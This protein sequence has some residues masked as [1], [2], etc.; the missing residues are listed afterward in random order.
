MGGTSFDIGTVVEVGSRADSFEGR[1][2][3]TYVPMIDRFRVGISMIETKSIGAGGGSIAHYNELLNLVDVG[4]ESAGSNPGPACFDLGGERPTVTDAD[5]A[6]GL[7]DPDYFLG[8]HM[9][10]N[11]EAAEEAI[12]RHLVEPLGTSVEEAAFLVKTIIDAK[13][14]NEV[15]KETNL[16]GYDP[17]EFTLFAFGGAGPTH[18][19]GYANYVE[20]PRIMTFPFSSVF[21]AFGVA[22]T[23]FMRTYERSCK[24]PLYTAYNDRWLEDFDEFNAIVRDLQVEALR[25]ADDLGVKDV[26]WGLELYLRYGMQPHVTRIRSPRIFVTD[27]DDVRE[28]YRAYETEYSRLYSKAATFLAGGVEITGMTLW[29]VVPTGKQDLPTLPLEG[30]DPSA[31]RRG[32]G[33]RS[34]GPTA[35]GWRP[36]STTSSSSSRG[37]RWRAR[38]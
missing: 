7:V 17:R 3:Y 37:T 34:G 1:H 29:S 11:K 12:R 31:A 27:P 6:L 23:D 19:C 30:P 33:P 36:T 10:L 8:G 28:V 38:R 5:V 4:P 32:S 14:G 18:V 26:L 13:M 20:T 2:F 9:A 22:N 35:A 24:I 25:D 21:S 15:F 16:K